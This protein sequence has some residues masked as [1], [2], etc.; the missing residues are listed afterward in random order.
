MLLGLGLN[1]CGF[2]AVKMLLLGGSQRNTRA[3]ANSSGRFIK[4]QP[5]NNGQPRQLAPLALFRLGD[6]GDYDCR[7]RCDV[8]NNVKIW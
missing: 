2:N 4:R 3:A 8:C 5:E 1:F 7:R 6:G